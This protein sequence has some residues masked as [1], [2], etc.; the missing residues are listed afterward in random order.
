[1]LLVGF[2][3]RIYHDSQ[4][5]ECQIRQ[6]QT[7]VSVSLLLSWDVTWRSLAVIDVSGQNVGPI[8]KGILL[9]T[10][11]VDCPKTSARNYRSVL[12]NI[13][14]EQASQLDFLY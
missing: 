13:P 8:I 2:I 14:E 3:I 1:M 11:P 12:R 6:C 10:G 5:S 9:K 7:R 4:P